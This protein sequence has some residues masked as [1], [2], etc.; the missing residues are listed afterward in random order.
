MTA[1]FAIG[2]SY[3]KQLPYDSVRDFAPVSLVAS[4]PLVIVAHPALA[5]S[6]LSEF[7]A[8]AMR[9]PKQWR[10]SSGGAGGINHLVGELLNISAGIQL[11]HV[12]YKGAGPAL[13][14]VISGE[15]QLIVATLGSV[16]GHLETGKLKALAIGSARRSVSAPSISTVAESGLSGYVAENWYGL[17]APRATPRPII[18]VLNARLTESLQKG[19]L[20]AQLLKL[21]FEA[22]TSTPGE[23]NEYLRQDI[24]KW[25]C[26]LN[27][28]GLAAGA[29]P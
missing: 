8:V 11:T 17:L 25:A 21:G 23:F 6:S 27:S 9:R 29:V 16:V 24:A 12:P 19:D 4:V 13:L 15:T 10:Y 20:R 2:A 7:V 22:L 28:A 18:A 1:S 26:V 5:V 3:Y 14:S